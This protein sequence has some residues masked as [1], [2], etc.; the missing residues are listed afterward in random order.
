[1]KTEE[2]AMSQEMQ[3]ASRCWKRKQ[4]RFFPEAPEE[5]KLC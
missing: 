1:M 4:N 2:G 5:M 3:V